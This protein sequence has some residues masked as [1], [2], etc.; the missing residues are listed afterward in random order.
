MSWT[1]AILA[2]GWWLLGA[3]L[4]LFF[5]RSVYPSRERVARWWQVGLGAFGLLAYLV[6]T[7]HAIS[8]TPPGF[9]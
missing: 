8:Q 6:V 4:L 7:F 3:L 9:P 1:Q 5:V 2:V